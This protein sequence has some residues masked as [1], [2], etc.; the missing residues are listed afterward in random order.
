MMKFDN[1]V[2]TFIIGTKMDTKSVKT[3]DELCDMISF[4]R[5]CICQDLNVDE[6]TIYENIRKVIKYI[7]IDGLIL[8]RQ[9]MVIKKTETVSNI[10]LCLDDI[11][12]IFISNTHNYIIY[13]SPTNKTPSLII[14]RLLSIHYPNIEVITL[15]IDS[16]NNQLYD[17][18]NWISALLF[19]TITSIYKECNNTEV[20]EVLSKQFNDNEFRR[21]FDELCNVVISNQSSVIRLDTSRPR[22]A[23]SLT[24]KASQNLNK[25][26]EILH[27]IVIWICGMIKDDENVR[28]AKL[29]GNLVKSCAFE[30]I[31]KHVK[32]SKTMV[33][34]TVIKLWNRL[35]YE[36]T[37]NIDNT[38]LIKKTFQN[39]IHCLTTHYKYLVYVFINLLQFNN[40]DSLISHHS[41]I[42]MQLTEEYDD[43]IKHLTTI[44]DDMNSLICDVIARC[45][46]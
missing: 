8:T 44:S 26:L 38:Q 20:I 24:N 15:S 23:N 33:H 10:I 31:K 13:Y 17:T 40:E 22:D 34:E 25:I 36:L 35:N 9:N 45:S 21:T 28:S 39:I 42:I 7:N 12:C 5:Q 43:K 3:F 6:Y 37:L 46:T 1:V 11:D 16:N 41:F 2:T 14:R 29:Y 30:K 4:A 18:T 19:V 32:I 27:D